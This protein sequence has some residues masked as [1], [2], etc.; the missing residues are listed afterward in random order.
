[1]KSLTPAP[2]KRT[3]HIEFDIDENLLPMDQAVHV[4]LN[5]KVVAT[6]SPSDEEENAI[7]VTSPKFEG[8]KKNDPFTRAVVFNHGDN[9]PPHILIKFAERE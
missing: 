3:R 1:M 7:M 2:G 4:V 6:I 9:E 8:A 5:G